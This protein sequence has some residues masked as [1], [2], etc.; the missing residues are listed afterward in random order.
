M[1][2]LTV[3]LCIMLAFWKLVNSATNFVVLNFSSH[4]H[5]L[6]VHEL[7]L[8]NIFCSMYVDAKLLVQLFV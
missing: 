8:I 7:N 5:E 1:M 6:Y 3:K 4:R 2:M